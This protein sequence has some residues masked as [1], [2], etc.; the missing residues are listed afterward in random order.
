MKKLPAVLVFVVLVL[1]A[2]VYTFS[3]KQ[4]I[5]PKGENEVPEAQEAPEGKNV[6]LVTDKGFE[7]QVLGVKA[8]ETVTWIN[9]SN[10]TV[11]VSSDTHPIHTLFPFLNIGNIGTNTSASATVEEPGTYTY[12]N[13]LDPTKT[14]TVV[15]Q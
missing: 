8:G 4:V 15:A 7:P 9:T 6:V 3:A 1:I 5:A 13:H 14:G 2:L 11:N 12:H 10:K